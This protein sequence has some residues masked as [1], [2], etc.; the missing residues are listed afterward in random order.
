MFGKGVRGRWPRR[1]AGAAPLLLLLLLLPLLLSACADRREAAFTIAAASGFQRI[2]F[3]APPFTLIGYLRGGGRELIVYIEG[4]G[5]AWLSRN[6]LS[7]DPTPRHPT[8]LELATADPSPAVL[9][10]AR[11]CQQVT[12]AEARGCAPAYWS[13]HRFAPEVI[14]ATDHAIDEAVRRT[15]AARVVLIGYSGG[16]A[17]AALT[18]AQRTDVAALATLAAPLDHAAWTARHGVSAL[19]GSLNPI[20]AAARLAAL[21]QIHFAGAEDTVVPPEIIHSFLTR[22]GSLP[23]PGL[24]ILPGVDHYCCWVQRWPELRPLIPRSR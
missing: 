22:E 24:V 9:Y 13:S 6:R 16:G 15:G 1:G 2:A 19:T 11:P 14:A 5:L 3:D 12:P 7:E 18:A 4:D 21:A 23:E 8:A 10:L 20:D 17:V